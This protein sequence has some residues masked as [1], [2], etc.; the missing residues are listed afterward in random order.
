MRLKNKV[1]SVE[2]SAGTGKTY[3]LSA[4]YVALLLCGAK[5]DE[6]LCLTFTNKSANDMKQK[7]S[8]FIDSLGDDKKFLQTI[9]SQIDI[10]LSQIDEKKQQLKTNFLNTTNSIMTIDKFLNLVLKQFSWYLDINENYKIG[11]NDI[12]KIGFEFLKTLDKK[13]FADILQLCNKSSKNFEAILNI[14]KL[15]QESSQELNFAPTQISSVDIAKKDVIQKAQAISK[16]VCSFDTA[17]NSAIKAVSFDS[18]DDIFKSSWIQKDYFKEFSYFKKLSNDHAEV[19]FSQ[20]KHSSAIYFKTKNHY[21]LTKLNSVYKVW[22]N[23]TI[24]NMIKTN[25][26]EFVDVTN[27]VYELLNKKIT[28]DFLYYRLDNKYSHILL[29]E[30]QDISI[31]Q[32]NVLK[33]LID[34][35]TSQEFESFR[36]FFYV[37]DIKQSIYRFRG[38]E[39]GLFKH[40]E[41]RYNSKKIQLKENFRTATNI[42]NFVYD[43]FKEKPNYNMPKPTSNISGGFV[44]VIDTND[45]SNS[46]IHKIKDMQKE[47]VN[48]ND[49]AILAYKNDDILS[50]YENIKKQLPFIKVST[51]TTSRLINSPKPKAVINLIK[52]LYYDETIYKENFHAI[53]GERANQTLKIKIDIKN[54]SPTQ[55]VDKIAKFYNLFDENM[56]KFIEQIK[57]YE[58]ITDFVF[59]INQLD[60]SITNKIS[61]GITLLTM[62]K[63]KG[64]EFG[65]VFVVDRFTKKPN[66]TNPLLLQYENTKLK[67]VYIKDPLLNYFDQDYKEATEQEKNLKTIDELN[68]LYVALTR[69][70]HNLV[71]F[72]KLQNSSIN[73]KQNTKIGEL[74]VC[75]TS[76]KQE[77]IEKN[78]SYKNI[79]YGRQNM[80]KKPTDTAA[81]SLYLLNFGIA[82]HYCL[83][84]M[85]KFDKSS[86]DKAIKLTMSIHNH[87]LSE[88]DFD[89]MHRMCHLLILNQEFQDKIKGKI[90]SKEQAILYNREVSVIDLL[91]T[92]DN[93]ITIFDYKTGKPQTKD[94][95]QISN[96]KKAMKDITN[97]NI[98][99]YILYLSTSG[100]DILEVD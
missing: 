58:N 23:F 66:D 30:F 94:K 50:I 24:Q 10:S 75:D 56:V 84:M 18:F 40:L 7:I 36:S 21:L 87:G 45:I 5:V 98:S 41:K 25:K 99:A 78:I 48:M 80:S 63:A 91:A 69:A 33:P 27:M 52:Y 49:I 77:K 20:F 37:G 79:D 54:G 16:F 81:S 28:N 68:V 95:T 1:V 86:L 73:I 15:I 11:K 32:Y 13:Q 59:N 90:L 26:L 85:N 83:E 14:F 82:T 53:L 42:I 3:N 8:H 51:D 47:G 70:K 44:E 6:I 46:I 100:V 2:A 62:F 35:I 43:V 4:R 55:I 71:V 72:Q 60:S 38:G 22:Q 76:N 9:Q 67:R 89:N 65:T 39:A 61:N 64:L 19:L 97:K 31:V 92:E 88:N 12:D 74:Y 29:D 57:V 93:H 96:Y 34:E 17:S